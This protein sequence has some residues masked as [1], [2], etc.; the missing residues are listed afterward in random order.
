MHAELL[1]TSPLR[2][3][4][5]IGPQIFRDYY[6]AFETDLMLLHVRFTCGLYKNKVIAI[7]KGGSENPSTMT[8]VSFHIEFFLNIRGPGRVSRIIDYFGVREQI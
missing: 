8:Q 5:Y 7:N 4:T 2:L 1:K 6:I 3:N